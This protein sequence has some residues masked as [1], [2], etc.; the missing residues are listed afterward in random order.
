MSIFKSWWRILQ[1]SFGLGAGYG[2]GVLLLAR[3]PYILQF[4]LIVLGYCCYHIWHKRLD[5]RNFLL[6]FAAGIVAG[7]GLFRAID[8]L[9]N[10]NIDLRGEWKGY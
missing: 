1:P 6:G 9:T 3:T 4:T 8:G 10:I 2:F 7:I 5:V